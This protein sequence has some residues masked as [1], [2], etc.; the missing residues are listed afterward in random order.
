M[1]FVFGAFSFVLLLVQLVFFVASVLIALF[2][3]ERWL[4]RRFI[5]Q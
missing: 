3:W 4:R 2:I 5:K 1:N